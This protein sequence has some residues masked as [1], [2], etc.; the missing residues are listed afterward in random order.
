MMTVPA[1]RARKG[2]GPPL[3]V[4]TAYDAM[5]TAAAEAA[6]VDALLVGDSLGM[7]ELGHAS[8]LPVTMEDMLHHARAVGRGRRE[9]LLV[10]DMPWLSYHVGP[11]AAVENAARFVREAGA[12]AV[13]IEGG[14][15]RLEVLRALADA[16]IPVM[17]HL[18]LTP[19]SVLPMGGYKVQGRAKRD[20]DTLVEDAAAIVSAGVFSIV[21]E[22][23]PSELATRITSSVDVPTIGIGAGAGCDGQ[24]LVIHDLLGML[25]GPV[26]KFVRR[27]AD[28]HGAAVEGIRSWA[29]DVRERRFPSKD[30]TYG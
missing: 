18:G 1:F 29:S 3:V 15:K 26:P 10:V 16:E 12:D 19:Q 24:V 30:E 23:I 11:A 27:Y 7:V 14:A 28:L 4:L 25:P 9:A 22:G 13:K 8:T 6:G 17:G 20:A 5:T 21:L 2:P